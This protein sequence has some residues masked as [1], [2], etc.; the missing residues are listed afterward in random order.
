[1]TPASYA[2]VQ[3][4]VRWVARLIRVRRAMRLPR[5]YTD[6][7]K[8]RTRYQIGGERCWGSGLPRLVERLERSARRERGKLAG[9]A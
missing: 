9:K 7:V 1:M 5:I 8:G 2:A 6:V 4:E 3:D